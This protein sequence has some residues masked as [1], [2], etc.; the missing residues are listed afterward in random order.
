MVLYGC[1]FSYWS[2]FWV[3]LSLPPS[4]EFSRLRTCSS[5]RLFRGKPEGGEGRG[6]FFLDMG[7]LTWWRLGTSRLKR[8][9]RC[10]WERIRRETR[11]G[12]AVTSKGVNAVNPRVEGVFRHRY[13]WESREWLSPPVKE[14]TGKSSTVLRQRKFKEG[15]REWILRRFSKFSFRASFLG[16]RRH[17]QVS[18]SLT[19]HQAPRSRR[20]SKF[21]HVR[22]CLHHRFTYR[23]SMDSTSQLGS[24]LYAL[25]RYHLGYVSTR[26]VST[27]VSISAV[28]IVYN[29]RLSMHH[30][31][32]C[33]Y[34]RLLLCRSTS[35][36]RFELPSRVLQALISHRPLRS[37]FYVLPSAFSSSCRRRC[38]C[39]RLPRP[40]KSS[41]V[42]LCPCRLPYH[43]QQVQVMQSSQELAMERDLLS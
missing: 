12:N 4:L 36:V 11:R 19:F 21:Y 9:A 34:S 7:G 5:S 40:S 42:V 15:P 27:T 38:H 35:G 29:G 8:G 24:R 20:F 6:S 13:P 10:S 1:R 28:S 2:C 25:P 41:F 33:F 23:S 31:H 43:G 16:F 39:H 14:K 26:I 17:R 30:R 37:K 22:R 3:C 18:T 32:C